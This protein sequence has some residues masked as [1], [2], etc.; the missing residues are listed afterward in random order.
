MRGGM[1]VITATTGTL[2][3]SEPVPACAAAA[4]STHLQR[5]LFQLR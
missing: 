2:P 5:L 1:A 3:P 4:S